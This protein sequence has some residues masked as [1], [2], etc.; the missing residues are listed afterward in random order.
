MVSGLTRWFA[1]KRRSDSR[2]PMTSPA[3]DPPAPPNGKKILIVDDDAVILETTA[4]K[5][6]SKGY[7]VVT[8]LDGSA[9]LGAVRDERPDLILLDI[10]FP[11]NV[12][13]GGAVAWDGFT[14]MSWLRQ[15]QDTRSIPIIMLTG[16]DV[17]GAEERSLRSGAKAF[18]RKP[19]DHAGLLAFIK[20]TL[21]GGADEA[22]Q[23]V[24]GDF[25][26]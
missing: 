11:P 17:T 19:I 24:G 20:Q 15:F 6:R 10:L 7:A 8:A 22:Q 14:V 3:A 21:G 2:Q 26:V 18:F 9:A 12:A 4:S 23:G 16:Q 5:L 25:Q 13:Q 1:R